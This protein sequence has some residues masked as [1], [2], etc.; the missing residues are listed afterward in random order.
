LGSGESPL[1]KCIPP[2]F[3]GCCAYGVIQGRVEG[4]SSGELRPPEA[5]AVYFLQRA[6]LLA[7]QAL[8]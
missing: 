4:R 2:T 3:C 6:A 8:Y 5:E 1:P 7:L